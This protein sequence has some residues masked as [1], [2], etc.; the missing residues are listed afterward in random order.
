MADFQILKCLRN[1]RCVANVY[2]DFLVNGCIVPRIGPLGKVYGGANP[3]FRALCVVS[4]FQ[5][6]EDIFKSTR[7]R[8]DLPY[9]IIPFIL[10]CITKRKRIAITLYIV[11][12]L[13]FLLLVWIGLEYVCRDMP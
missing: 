7:W 5:W 9:Y 4:L 2:R 3:F 6:I 8:T 11:Y 12:V 1:T 10:F 13:S